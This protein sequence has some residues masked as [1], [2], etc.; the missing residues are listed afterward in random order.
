M[1]SEFQ[2]SFLF[3]RVVSFFNFGTGDLMG[4]SRTKLVLG[5]RGPVTARG[6]THK[7]VWKICSSF[8][9]LSDLTS[10]G[11]LGST[12]FASIECVVHGLL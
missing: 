12:Q 11:V 1:M 2:S 8:D 3:L 6:G 9:C 5:S 10:S 4:W 7:T